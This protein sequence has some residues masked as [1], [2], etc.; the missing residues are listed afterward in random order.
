VKS[1]VLWPKHAEAKGKVVA[2]KTSVLFGDILIENEFL[3]TENACGQGQRFV[4][5][6]SEGEPGSDETVF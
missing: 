1:H 3:W 5:Q 6:N 2:L 4:T